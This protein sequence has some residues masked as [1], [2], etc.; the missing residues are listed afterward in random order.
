[1][2]VH[3][4]GAVPGLDAA[5]A[6]VLEAIGDQGVL[7]AMDLFVNGK[8]LAAERLRFAVSPLARKREADVVGADRDVGV[9]V[10]VG[11]GED[12]QRPAEVA[13]GYIEPRLVEER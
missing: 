1:M 13:F 4:H 12:G 6:E 10:A 5:H 2:Q 7:R 9:L 11:A 8:R 3:A